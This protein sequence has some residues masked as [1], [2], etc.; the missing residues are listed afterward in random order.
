[1]VKEN[2]ELLSLNVDYILKIDLIEKEKDSSLKEFEELKDDFAQKVGLLQAEIESK[3]E[4]LEIMKTRE[5]DHLVELAKAKQ[6]LKA[7]G[8]EVIPL[9][10]E[11]KLDLS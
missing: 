5:H 1:M 4:A 3:D 8:K 6:G 9:P 10:K 7:K 2:A 11:D